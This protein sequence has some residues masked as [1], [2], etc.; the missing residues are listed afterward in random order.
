M[1]I[2]ASVGLAVNIIMAA[3]LFGSRHE[4]LNVKGAFLHVVSDGLG[5][6]GA[7]VAAVAIILSG[8]YWV[9][10]LVSVLI[11]CLVL[12]SSWGLVRESVHILMEGVPLELNI[13]DIEDSIVGLDGVCCVYDLHVW[14]ITTH[15]HALSAHVVLSDPEYDRN[16]LLRELSELLRT[17]FSIDHSTVQIESGHEMRPDPEGLRCRAGTACA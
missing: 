5:S 1:L 9:D 2:I 13:R 17:Q 15:R 10:P 7:I 3:M 11:G 8:L 12:Y 14:S 6:V 16:L 4:N